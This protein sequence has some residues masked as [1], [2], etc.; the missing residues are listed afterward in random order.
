MTDRLLSTV[1]DNNDFFEILTEFIHQEIAGA[2]TLILE[3]G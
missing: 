1:N 2:Y 3:P